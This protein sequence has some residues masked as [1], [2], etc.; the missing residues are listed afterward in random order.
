MLDDLDLRK[1]RY[2]VAVA[3]ELNFIRA[4]DRLHIA[5]PVLTRQIKALEKELGVELFARSTRGTELTPAGAGFVDDARAILRSAAAVQRRVRQAARGGSR[6]TVGFM[7]GI[8]PTDLVRALRERIPDLAVEV[9]RTSWDDQVEMILDG[10]VDASF[11]RFP[12]DPSGLTVIPLYT[13]S[14]VV[15][16]SATHPLAARETVSILDLGPLDLLQDPAAVPEWRD[17]RSGSRER[18][19]ARTVEE[20]L[21]MVAGE[22]GVVILPE[23][24]ARFYTR[25]DVTHRLV[26]DLPPHQVALAFEAGRN[27]VELRVMAQIARE[28]HPEP[29]RRGM[30]WI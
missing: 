14:R 18:P 15:V 3:E 10:R 16:L 23:S 19:R 30:S 29:A 17:S 24:T 7:P 25:P 9:V 26:A 20:K 6:L 8:L 5:Q 11:V 12:I 22:R 1:L 28:Q 4:A 2:F 13:E 27:S 21:E